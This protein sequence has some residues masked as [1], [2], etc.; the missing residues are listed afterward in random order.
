MEL[1]IQVL[2]LLIQINHEAITAFEKQFA[3]ADYFS[4]SAKSGLGIK[5]T[6]TRLTEILVQSIE[7]KE[8]GEANETIEKLI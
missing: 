3:I 5:D 4:T 6:F 2:P 7:L 8:R 1:V